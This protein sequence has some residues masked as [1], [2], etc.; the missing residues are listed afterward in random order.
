MLPRRRR[1]VAKLSACALLLALA[2]CANNYVVLLPDDDGSLGQIQVSGPRGSTLL[3]QKNQATRIGGV[4]GQTFT[5]PDDELKKDFAAA[6]AARPSQPTRYNL[7]FEA[8][9][10]TL[11]AASRTEI[12]KIRADIQSRAAAD[13]SVIGHTDTKGLA[14]DNY[15]LGLTRASMVAELMR[16][17]EMSLDRVSIESHGETR[18]LLATPDETDEPLN[19]RVEVIVR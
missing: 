17:T 5:V 1:S 19:R 15:A 7:Y 6:L 8:G 2:G 4:E 16:S 3:D 18:L 12:N 9:R 13:L 11:T 14:Q 10:A